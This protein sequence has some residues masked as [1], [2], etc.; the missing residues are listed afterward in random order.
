MKGK[1]R[2]KFLSFLFFLLTFRAKRYIMNI[3]SKEIYKVKR[4]N[5]MTREEIIHFANCLK[6]NYTID[7]NDM[8]EFCN[9][10][11][12]SQNKL[13]W[14]EDLINDSSIGDT[15]TY[16]FIEGIMEND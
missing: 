16:D 11:I 13:Q 7:F 4:G 2:G 9:E 14:I 3:H 10:V 6:N 1:K 15:D 12:K 8:E 5:D